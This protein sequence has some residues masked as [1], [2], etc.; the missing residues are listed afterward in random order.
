MPST[1]SPLLRFEQINPGEQTASWGDNLMDSL[2]RLEEAIASTGAISTTGGDT[3]LTTVNYDSDQ[4][5]RA[6]LHVSGTLTS[7]SNI[8]VP[9]LSKLYVIV[10]ATTGAFTMSV[11]TSGGA[12]I[13]ITQGYSAL[14]RVRST[15]EVEFV[16]P[17]VATATG[18]L[19]PA[20]LT[21]LAPTKGRVI[22]GDGSAWQALTV[23]ANGYSLVADSAES[24]G[25][26]WVAPVAATMTVPEN[27]Y[28]H[29]N[30]H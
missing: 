24:L 21:G 30:L 26:K 13:A 7:N 22:V 10:N 15:G 16:G 8:I 2:L 12:A 28:M 6:I 3:T 14:L 17:Q 5:R 29:A 20:A 27:L 23:G 19:A 4:A 18:Y 1:A 9:A 11:K 25:V